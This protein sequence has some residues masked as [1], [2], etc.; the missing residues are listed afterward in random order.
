MTAMVVT[1]GGS[2]LKKVSENETQM[3]TLCTLNGKE[4]DMGHD[5]SPNSKLSYCTSLYTHA[6]IFNVFS[7]HATLC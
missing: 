7:V 1:N 3:Y 5:S 4:L 2:H 6:Q